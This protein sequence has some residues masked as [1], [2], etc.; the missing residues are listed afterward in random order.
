MP[1]LFIDAF[2]EYEKMLGESDMVGFSVPTGISADGKQ[3]LGYAFY[4]EDLYGG[5]SPAYY[6]TYVLSLDS[7]EDGVGLVNSDMHSI[8]DSIYSIDGRKLDR[9]TKGLNII[10]NTDGSVSKI[11]KK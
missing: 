3:I 2:P 4:S 1:E 9:M 6:L 5:D 10:R 8:S 11:L 7:T